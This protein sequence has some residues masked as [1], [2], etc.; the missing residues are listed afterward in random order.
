ML[1]ATL[2][3]FGVCAATDLGYCQTAPSVPNLIAYQGRVTLSGGSPVADGNYPATFTLYNHSS[4]GSSLWS[5]NA[6]LTTNSGTFSHNLGSITALP[7]TLTTANDSLWLA[8]VFNGE[9][10]S[11]RTRIIGNAFSLTANQLE[12]NNGTGV[13]ALR[14]NPTNHQLSQ[15]GS[16]GAERARLWGTEWPQFLMDA[17]TVNG[18]T[19]DI[20]LSTNGG[21]G[22]LIRLRKPTGGNGLSLY[23][24]TNSFGSTFSMTDPGGSTIVQFNTGNVGDDIVELPDNSISSPELFDEP[25]VASVVDTNVLALG[26]AFANVISRT[27]TV[28]SSGYVLAIGTVDVRP[29][30][31]STSGEIR[32]AIS[33]SSLTFASPSYAHDIDSLESYQCVTV[34]KTVSVAAGAHTFYLQVDHP[35]ASWGVRSRSLSLLYLP[36]SYG[37]VTASASA[38][39]DGNT[40]TGDP[41]SDMTVSVADGKSDLEAMRGQIANLQRRLSE[42]EAVNSALIIKKSD[43]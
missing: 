24:G 31:S 15:Y 16:D 43:E 32:A 40:G 2:M 34:H 23:S 38:I 14:T 5:E 22:S 20:E 35:N 12:M 25:G 39:E 13:T 26:G 36:T 7:T 9:L 33:T 21:D 1:S 11:P 30:G 42:L 41:D 37:S 6:N 8:I 3:M 27:I 10:L 4:G 17:N 19:D 18:S 29:T 28:P